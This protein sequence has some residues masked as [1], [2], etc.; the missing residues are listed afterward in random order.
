MAEPAFNAL[1]L[2]MLSGCAVRVNAGLKNGRLSVLSSS[3]FSKSTYRIEVV[4]S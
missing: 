1:L 3:V 4:S 2:A